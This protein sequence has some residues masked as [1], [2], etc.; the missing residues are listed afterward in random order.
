MAGHSKWH[1]IKNKKG[2]EDAKRAQVFSQIG[3]MIRMA[4]KEGKSDK[5]E[6]NPALRTALEKAKQANMPKENIQRAIDRG[7]G[8]SASGAQIQ[9]I[10]Y[11]GFGPGGVAIIAVALTDNPN[12]TSSDV[13]F[14]FSRAGGSLGSPGSAT[15]LFKR[16]STGNY[17]PTMTIPVSEPDRQKVQQLV[18]ALR[19]NEDI[20]DVYTAADL[21]SNGPDSDSPDSNNLASNSPDSE[22]E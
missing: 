12:R 22:K 7:M 20:E 8:R 16:D 19:A 14:A 9:E 17:V 18:A 10:S 3:K 1:N 15:Y 5:P 13:K 11:E 2:A 6:F 21:D 4:V